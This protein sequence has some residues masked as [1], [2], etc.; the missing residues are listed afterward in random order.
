MNAPSHNLPVRAMSILDSL[1]RVG[2]TIECDCKHPYPHTLSVTLNTPQACA[3]G[4]DLLMDPTSGW[5]LRRD[6]QP[7][8]PNSRQIN[9]T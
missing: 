7:K 9:T 3:L 2:N 1:A 8:L 5:R 6:L 4:N